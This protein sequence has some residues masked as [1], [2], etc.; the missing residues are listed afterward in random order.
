MNI[1]KFGYTSLYLFQ[2]KEKFNQDINVFV[3]FYYHDFAK[4]SLVET[5]IYIFSKKG[6]TPISEF[7]DSY[8]KFVKEIGN[9]FSEKD[10]IKNTPFETSLNRILMKHIFPHSI[11]ETFYFTDNKTKIPEEFL[12]QKEVIE[13]SQL[14]F[15]FN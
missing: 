7:S 15:N 5:P 8:K 14:T 6:L 4:C 2:A 12:E 3:S 10:I 11:M 13:D 1:K 9:E